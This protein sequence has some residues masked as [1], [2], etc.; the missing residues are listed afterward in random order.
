MK[1]QT[2]KL[3]ILLGFVGVLILHH[4]WGYLGHFGY[5]DLH[6]A[7]LAND[8]TN[9]IFNAEDH[10][11]F[12]ITLIG[13]TSLSYQLFGINDFASAL[14]ALLVT[15]VSSL[16][17]F[18]ILKK[19][20]PA[21]IT[22]GL[23][24]FSLSSWTLFY[25]DKLMP[26]SFVAFFALLTVFFIFQFKYRRSNL[27]IGWYAFAA[28]FSLFLGF[29][30]K[31]TIILLFPL[32]GYYL[33]ADLIA[34][35]NLKFWAYFALFF[36]SL[37]GSYLAFWQVNAGQA[38]VRFQSI[39]QNSYLNLC[40]YSEQ[41]FLFTLKRI[42]YEFVLLL[43]KHAMIVPFML[44]LALPGRTFRRRFFLLND[45]TSFFIGSAIVLLLSSNFMSISVT[46]YSPMCL[47]P[48]HYLFIV[49]IAAIAAALAMKELFLKEKAPL[50]LIL[51]TL[52]VFAISILMKYETSW[53]VY[54]LLLTALLIW[55]VFNKSKWKVVGFTCLFLLVLLI[56]PIKMIA[57]ARKINFRKQERIIKEQLL[58]RTEPCIVITD[59]VQKNVAKYL[60]GFQ[61]D[62][63]CKFY[64]YSEFEPTDTIPGVPVFVLKNWYT[65]YLSNLT[66]QNLPFYAQ[67]KQAGEVVFDD[68]VLN[69]QLFRIEE[70]R[71]PDVVFQ[72]TNNFESANSVW[73]GFQ[74]DEQ[75]VYSGSFSSRV[76]GY[77]S[78]ITIELDSLNLENL[79]QLI[80]ESTFYINLIDDADP[81]FV[82]SAER[83]DE[84]ALWKGISFK[85][86]MKSFGNWMPVYINEQIDL[87]KIKPGSVLKI[88]IFN[89]EQA[90]MY[91]DDFTVKLMVLSD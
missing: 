61:D 56:G 40:S 7:K 41:P 5:D 35:K 9:G 11:S 88:Y 57:Y 84:H 66:K 76:D 39:Y 27:S 29:N 73:S 52:V 16:L 38:F 86:Q 79:H 48:R 53:T 63:V 72:S 37:L 21:I 85:N 33:V 36:A 82:I 28:A 54:L 44:L 65:S 15:I 83:E 55:F 30:T 8:L 17:I 64:T 23:A 13:L 51:I 69:I 31:G 6:Y 45:E 59:Q 75:Y 22:I 4:S 77:S 19:E 43:I 18:F 68:S 3:L 58:S 26:D 50:R 67:E 70:F 25:S 87:D 10:F 34:K 71:E 49:P 42:S 81:S 2:I 90:E 74:K 62:S 47:D 60:D 20:K 32:L 91:L 80:I 12:R 78:T 1:D 14:P 89:P 24:L 46:S